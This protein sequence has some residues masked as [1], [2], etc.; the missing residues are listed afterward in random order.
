[1]ASSC[2]KN[3]VLDLKSSEVLNLKQVQECLEDIQVTVWPKI[4]GKYGICVHS[5][6]HIKFNAHKTGLTL[7]LQ[8]LHV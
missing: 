5:L 1:M 2:L 6:R 4:L 7:T 3:A 8:K